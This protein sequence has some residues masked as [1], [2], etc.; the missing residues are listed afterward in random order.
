MNCRF[1]FIISANIYTARNACTFLL[2]VLLPSNELVMQGN[3]SSFFA[4]A[5]L[6]KEDGLDRYLLRGL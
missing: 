3:L 2:L 6:D 5:R 4:C 1:S